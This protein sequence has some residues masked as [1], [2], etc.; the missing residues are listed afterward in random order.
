MEITLKVNNIEVTVANTDTEFN[1][2]NQTLDL[3]IAILRAVGYT[4]KA[5]SFGLKSI[6]I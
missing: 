1:G 3:M 2:I 6:K 4:E 5:I